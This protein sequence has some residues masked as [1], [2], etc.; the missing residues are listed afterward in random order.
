MKTFPAKTHV[1]LFHV[2]EFLLLALIEFVK[3]RASLNEHNMVEGPDCI[4]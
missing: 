1:F 3:K 2:D 4:H